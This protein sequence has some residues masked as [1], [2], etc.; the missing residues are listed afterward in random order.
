MDLFASNLK[1]LSKLGYALMLNGRVPR[2]IDSEECLLVYNRT[3]AMMYRN[4]SLQPGVE[5]PVLYATSEH[6]Y[7]C[8]PQ[9]VTFLTV[10]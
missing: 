3:A 10:H 9:D 5:P 6:H 2:R 1:A 8:P 4:W 7:L